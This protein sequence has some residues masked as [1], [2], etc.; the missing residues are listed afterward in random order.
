MSLVNTIAV[1]T[2]I[3][4]VLEGVYWFVKKNYIN[5]VFDKS[6]SCYEP[7]NVKTVGIVVHMLIELFAIIYFLIL[8]FASVLN[9][10]IFGGVISGA[11]E[12]CNYACIKDHND[13]PHSLVNV[14]VK[15]GIYALTVFLSRL[16]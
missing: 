8:G 14:V 16:I 4:L 15:S 5:K 2:V 1:P 3:F 7:G 13:I 10:A 9:S 12:S 6:D 11:H